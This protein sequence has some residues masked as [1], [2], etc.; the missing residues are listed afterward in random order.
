MSNLIN[1]FFNFFVDK[2]RPILVRTSLFIGLIIVSL[3]LD[4]FFGFSFF[5]TSNQKIKQIQSIEEIK[6]TYVLDTHISHDLSLLESQVLSHISF[7]RKM[8]RTITNNLVRTPQTQGDASVSSQEEKH[9]SFILLTISSAWPFIIL[10]VIVLSAPFRKSNGI[11]PFTTF[12]V[13]ISIC[14]ILIIF[15]QF[16]ASLIPILW[17]PWVNYCIYAIGWFVILTYMGK[18]LK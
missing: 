6:R 17:R 13:G 8:I 1:N 3:F 15:C 14:V 2:D 18:R 11:N 16:I 4:N 12:I 7:P 5:Y 9:Y 10:L